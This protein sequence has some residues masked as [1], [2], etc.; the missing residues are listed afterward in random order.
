MFHATFKN[1]LILRIKVIDIPKM[2]SL[3]LYNLFLQLVVNFRKGHLLI[4]FKTNIVIQ[5]I[6][7]DLECKIALTFD[8]GG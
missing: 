7:S 1:I 3:S 4:Y 2:T 8:F 6:N 5:S